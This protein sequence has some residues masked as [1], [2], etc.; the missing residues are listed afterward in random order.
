MATASSLAGSTSVHSS[1]SSQTSRSCTEE[2]S[3]YLSSDDS[4][5][6]AD[7][8]DVPRTLVHKLFPD[9]MPPKELVRPQ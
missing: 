5:T 2:N 1:Q 8:R 6:D 7:A 9:Q 4:D 3:I